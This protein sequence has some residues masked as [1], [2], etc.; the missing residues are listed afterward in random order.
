MA[1]AESLAD[2][3]QS[4]LPPWVYLY[5][6]SRGRVP[7]IFDQ[8][9]P[10]F[11]IRQ[12]DG[13]LCETKAGLL[14]EFA[15]RLHFPGY[16]GQNWDALEECLTDLEWLPATGYLI[17]MTDA[18][19]VLASDEAG[20]TTFIQILQSCGEEWAAPSGTPA[21]LTRP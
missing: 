5:I 7:E 15:H 17:I 18:E 19:H 9:P 12:I 1:P 14:S 3:V 6:L 10:G 8:P 4:I 11:I 2:H 21:C 16:F 13:R 20:Y